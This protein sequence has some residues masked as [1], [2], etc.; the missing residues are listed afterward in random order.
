[1][2]GPGH[3]RGTP[4]RARPARPVSASMLAARACDDRAHAEIGPA[5]RS[6]EVAPGVRI[7]LDEL[8]WRFSTS[9]GPGGQHVNTSNTR[10]EVRF[11]VA[12]SPS[13]PAW[14]RE[15]H[16][17]APRAGGH[18]HRQRRAVAGPQPGRCAARPPGRPALARALEVAPAPDDATRP[19][20]ASQRRRLEAK[21]RQ[22]RAQAASAGSAGCGRRR[23]RPESVGAGHGRAPPATRLPSSGIAAAS[24]WRVAA[25][26]RPIWSIRSSTDSKRAWPRRWAT[27]STRAG[28]P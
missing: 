25:T 19:T 2:I 6:C 4:I 23:L 3:S 5:G 12:A 27:N 15:R 21:R 16:P 14:A 20:R 13:L 18:G 7:P 22:G 8:T 11:D 10:A 24:I 17:G 9:G 28:S 1:M 26:S